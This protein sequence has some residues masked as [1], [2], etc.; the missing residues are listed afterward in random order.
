MFGMSATTPS[1][2]FQRPKSNLDG[3]PSTDRHPTIQDAI[4]WFDYEHLP[5][6]LQG[7]SKQCA[8]LAESL[9]AQLPDSPQLALGLQKLLEAKDCFV[10]AAKAQ[11]HDEAIKLSAELQEVR[12]AA[13]R[14]LDAR[15]ERVS[16]ENP[17]G[18]E[19]PAD[20]GPTLDFEHIARQ[21]R[22]FA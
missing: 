7:F 14:D 10:R 18:V 3:P 1:P 15:L 8:L 5:K 20:D 4:S 16:P 2:E 9:L 21:P 22:P 12:K 13:I 6:H 19:L 11:Q 17:M